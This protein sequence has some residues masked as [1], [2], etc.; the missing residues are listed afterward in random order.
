MKNRK[1]K[2][3]SQKK[4]DH[5]KIKANIKNRMKQL[6][7]PLAKI[8]FHNPADTELK[9]SAVILKIADPL[10]MRYKDN[11]KLIYTIIFLA[12]LVWNMAM[13][14]EKKQEDYYDKLIDKVLPKESTGEEVAAFMEFIDTLMNRENQYFPDINRIIVHHE[15]SVSGGNITLNVTSAPIGNQ[16]P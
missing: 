4:V 14:P 11:D 3:T 5:Q 2:K 7:L 9:M 8:K 6:G 12:I 10:I 13:F 16:K 1:A 15:L